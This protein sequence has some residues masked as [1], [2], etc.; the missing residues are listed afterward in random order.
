MEDNKT[1]DKEKEKEKSQPEPVMTIDEYFDTIEGSTK[2]YHKR[3]ITAFKISYQ[4]LDK[5]LKQWEDFLADK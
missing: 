4:G 1:K 2:G 5:T 3:S